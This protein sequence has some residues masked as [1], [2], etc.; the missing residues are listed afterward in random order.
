MRYYLVHSHTPLIFVQVVTAPVVAVAA[1]VVV[2]A[3]VAAE[4]ATTAAA[5][6]VVVVVAVAAVTGVAEATEDATDGELRWVV[7]RLIL[8]EVPV[9]ATL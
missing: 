5:T 8:H 3:A 6:V 2:A 1:G 9:W 4:V 7:I